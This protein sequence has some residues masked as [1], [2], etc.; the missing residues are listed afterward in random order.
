MG[1]APG[2]KFAFKRREAVAAR[3]Y[4]G[5]ARPVQDRVHLANAIWYQREQLAD[6][7]RYVV[8][9]EIKGPIDPGCCP[10]VRGIDMNEIH[11]LQGNATARCRVG[12]DCEIVQVFWFDPRARLDLRETPRAA[13]QAFQ[14]IGSESDAIERECGFK[15]RRHIRVCHQFS[16]ASDRLGMPIWPFLD[17]NTAGHEQP[18]GNPNISSY[19][20][21]RARFGFRCRLRVMP[22]QPQSACALKPGEIS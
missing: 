5:R 4:L 6:L 3:S 7:V 12:L 10:Y 14:N 18:C 21:D 20:K 13:R 9:L 1:R 15:N 2:P 16:R 17:K 11:L 22:T 19:R 8:A